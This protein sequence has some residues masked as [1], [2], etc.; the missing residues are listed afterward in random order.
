MHVICQINKVKEKIHLTFSIDTEKTFDR[1]Q[2]LSMTK[3]QTRIVTKE[4]NFT[5]IEVIYIKLITNTTN[6][7]TLN[8]FTL[9]R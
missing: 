9:R 2:H 6:G 1:V 5:T 8:I 3:I 7:E 4:L